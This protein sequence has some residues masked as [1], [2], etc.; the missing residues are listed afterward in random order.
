[1]FLPIE[2]TEDYCEGHNRSRWRPSRGGAN[3]KGKRAEPPVACGSER[4]F[5]DAD[6]VSVASL[7]SGSRTEFDNLYKIGS[8]CGRQRTYENSGID[9]LSFSL[10][11][12]RAALATIGRKY[13][14]KRLF[15]M[16]ITVQMRNA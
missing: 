13:V 2:K 5:G 14:K 9:D 4:V 12:R 1:M 11:R 10:D 16:S 15:V 7:E 8:L 6:F 3:G